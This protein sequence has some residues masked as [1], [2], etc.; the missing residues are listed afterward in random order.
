MK[1][2]DLMIF[3]LDGTLVTSGKDIAASVSY[4]LA[5]M[6]LPALDETRILTFIGDGVKKLIERSL[7]PALQARFE[8]ALGLFSRHYEEHMLDST[9][10]YPEV[11]E[12]L[13]HF[14]E[15]KKIVLTNKRHR[16]AVDMCAALQLTPCF[17]D[18]LGAD[19]TPYIKPDARLA[20]ALLARFHARPERTV[21]VG[22]GVNDILL[23]K[24][25]GLIS[26]ALLNGL[27]GRETLLNLN[28]DY[29]CEHLSE[30]TKTFY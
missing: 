28:P 21:I 14:H 27:T 9:T 8:E 30:I 26:C 4:T 5:E 15:K 23:A 6:G 19:S 12:V 1:S 18:I 3:D 20:D 7:G 22:D 29:S 24:N 16:F 11:A 13:R 2:V 25:A 10:L 17:D